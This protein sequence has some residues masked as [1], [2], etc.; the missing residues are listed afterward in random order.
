MNKKE[1]KT[2][3]ENS[4]EYLETKD[5]AAEEI[6]DSSAEKNEQ[7]QKTHRKRKSQ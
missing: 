1:E 2:L 5:T 6:N 7:S 3:V 4:D